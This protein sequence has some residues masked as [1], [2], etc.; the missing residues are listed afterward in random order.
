MLSPSRMADYRGVSINT[1]L[2]KTAT[3]TLVLRCEIF[4]PR[5]PNCARNAFL[6]LVLEHFTRGIRTT[7]KRY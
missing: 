7:I 5:E 6:L 4:K 2:S 3:K 1:P